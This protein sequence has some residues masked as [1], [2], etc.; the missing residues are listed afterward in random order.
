MAA[1]TI[2]SDFGTQK[3]KV[4]HCFHCFP[5]YFPWS[6]GSWVW[7]SAI[8]TALFT[9]GEDSAGIVLVAHIALASKR[10]S[11]TWLGAGTGWQPGLPLHLVLKP[12]HSVSGQYEVSL[13]STRARVKALGLLRPRPDLE[14][15]KVT[16]TK[17][18][19]PKPTQP[20]FK[21]SCNNLLGRL[22]NRNLLHHSPGG[23]KFKTRLSTEMVMS[24]ASLL[25]M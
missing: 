16:Y 24:E 11:P 2:C 10:T 20:T 14:A 19:S 13:G 18:L 1:V 7:G 5:I 4:W 3:N 17:F 25:G 22:H 8:W 12:S 15:L 9:E 23:W 21:G 6:G